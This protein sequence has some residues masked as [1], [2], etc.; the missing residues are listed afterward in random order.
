MQE[1]I[2]T[3]SWQMEKVAE[4]LQ[5]PYLVDTCNAIFDFTYNNFQYKADDEDQLLRSPA[6]SWYDRHNGIDCKSYS[7][8][9]SAILLEMGINHYIRKIKQ[10]SFAPSEYTHV[11]VIVPVNQQTNDLNK[12]YYVIDGTVRDNK[13]PIFITAKDEF[14]SGLQHYALN[15][16]AQPQEHNTGL[17]S[18]ST[19]AI[20]YTIAHFQD[21][22]KNISLN[23]IKSWFSHYD[24]IGGTAFSNG[25]ADTQ[26]SLV[27]GMISTLC[28]KIAV[29]ISNKDMVSLKNSVADL[30]GKTRVYAAA[31][32][33]KRSE[34][35]NSCSTG[36]MSKI[37]DTVNTIYDKVTIDLLNQYLKQY[38]TIKPTGQKKNYSIASAGFGEYG[39]TQWI[40]GHD[41]NFDVELFDFTINP[42]VT[43]IPAFEFT[44]PVLDFIDPTKFGTLKDAL[45][46]LTN[47]IADYTKPT[48]PSGTNPSGTT[49]NNPNTGTTSAGM[50]VVGGLLILSAIFY[51]AKQFTNPTASKTTARKTTK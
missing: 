33:L 9:A 2:N 21:W 29:D 3:Y 36:N 30:R 5:K 25:V 38:F 47:V 39:I 49:T 7:I 32:E 22:F 16:P 4:K 35:W 45:H 34:R 28:K 46:S 17:N 44:Q 23:N 37:I 11:Y 26:M 12:G 1:V 41:W 18:S 15:A 24:C 8:L 6:C 31:I 13:E 50:G 10:P 40:D 42:D 14:M 43:T 27:S 48:T 20:K 19:D 51:G